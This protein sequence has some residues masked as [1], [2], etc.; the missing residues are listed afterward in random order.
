MFIEEE[1][2]IE[3]LTPWIVVVDRLAVLLLLAGHYMTSAGL[4]AVH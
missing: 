3:Y 2:S 4:V 1:A